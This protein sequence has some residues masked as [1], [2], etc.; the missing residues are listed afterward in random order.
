MKNM[1]ETSST[2]HNWKQRNAILRSRPMPSNDDLKHEL[3]KLEHL[4]ARAVTPSN[5]RELA[6]KAAINSNDLIELLTEKLG[7]FGVGGLKA[8]IDIECHYG[9]VTCL[10]FLNSL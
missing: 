5:Y 10:Q 7:S 2:L 8:A 9:I 1:I 3:I 4:L 6:S